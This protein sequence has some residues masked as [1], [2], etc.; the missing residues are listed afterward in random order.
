MWCKD[1]CRVNRWK[2]YRAVHRLRC[3]GF[4]L[5]ADSVYSGSNLGCSKHSSPLFLGLVFC[6]CS[7][8][9]GS[10]CCP[11]GWLP[12]VPSKVVVPNKLLYQELKALTVIGFMV[13]VPMVVASQ[14]PI[15]LVW[16]DPHWWGQFEVGEVPDKGQ[17]SIIG[18]V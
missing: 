3:W 9:C 2:G 11:A 8:S 4:S 13:M 1:P 18:D 7:I 10:D 6:H 15:A 16:T 14:G 5:T 12:Q 17:K